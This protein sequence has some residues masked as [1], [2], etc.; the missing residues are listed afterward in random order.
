[1][2]GAMANDVT[3]NGLAGLRILCL[4]SRRSQEMAKLISNYGG[5]PIVAPS[6]QEVT[7]KDNPEALAFARK[8]ADGGFDVII[9][10]TGVGTRALV[11]L[12][13]TH[14]MRQQFVDAL[15]RVKVVAR[16]PKPT[17]A[18]AEF[19]VPVTVAVPEPNMWREVL[20]AL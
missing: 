11:R 13:E 17:A 16:G 19:G 5:E 10:L 1:M 4:E 2:A 14:D 3:K 15:K 20:A 18:L 7:L 12:V 9:F 6:M 8:L